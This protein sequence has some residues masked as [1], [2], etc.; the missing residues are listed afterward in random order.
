MRVCSANDNQKD[1][2]N[3]KKYFYIFKKLMGLFCVLE[4]KYQMNNKFSVVTV[5]M[6]LCSQIFNNNTFLGRQQGNHFEKLSTE[7]IFNI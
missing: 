1:S 4:N 6:L 5:S 3:S 7:K 2:A